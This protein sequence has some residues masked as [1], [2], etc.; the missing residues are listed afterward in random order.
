MNRLISMI[1]SCSSFECRY[2]SVCK[3]G[4]SDK[5]FNRDIWYCD[6]YLQDRC[7]ACAKNP[8]CNKYECRHFRN[9]R[10]RNSMEQYFNEK[11]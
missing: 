1:F 8:L 6:A 10:R 5:C 7:S 2:Q 3:D 9:S 11:I 4:G